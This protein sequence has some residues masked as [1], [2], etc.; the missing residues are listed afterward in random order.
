MKILYIEKKPHWII[1][2]CLNDKG[3]LGSIPMYRQGEWCAGIYEY[4]PSITNYIR[5]IKKELKIL[6]ERGEL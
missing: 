3:M 6:E 4:V 2:Y 1:V 5:D